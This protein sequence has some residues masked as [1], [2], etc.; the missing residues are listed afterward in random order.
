MKKMKIMTALLCSI[1][2][3]AGCGAKTESKP[4]E[5][6]VETSVETPAETPAETPVETSGK[7]GTEAVYPEAVAEDTDAGTFVMGEAHWDWWEKYRG[8]VDVSAGQQTGMEEYY[9]SVIR[10]LLVTDRNENTVCSP[11]NIYI[12]LSMLAEASDGNTR[13]QILNVLKAGDIEALRS[14]TKALW[15][16]NYLDTPVVKS[17]LADSMWLR[18]D[19][20]YRED[21][22]QRMADLYY[23]SSF[24]GEM[25]SEE[26][27]RQ[28]QEWTDKNTGGLLSEYTK[29]MR[30]DER[31]VLGIISTIYYKA[32]WTDRFRPDRTDKAVFHGAEGDTEVQMM[33]KD[34]MMSLYRT[35][36]FQAVGLSLSDSGMMYFFLPEEGTDVKD[37]AVDAETMSICRRTWDKESSYPIVHLSVPKF[38]V[39]QKTELLDSLERLGITDALDPDLADFAPLTEEAGQIWLN[40]AEH[41]AVVEIDEEGVTG[42]A[43]TDLAMAGAGMPQEE[44]DFVLDKPFFFA[45]VSPDGSI[46]FSGIVQTIN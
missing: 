46:L 2:I 30:L 15:E 33:H 5:A 35:E 22:L 10:E 44:V 13:E 29:D 37:V 24:C 21:T 41:A 45:I 38:K 20:T 14:R 17:L 31:T 26:L 32:A 11:L 4:A 16:A 43:Y 39:S 9:A 23:A 42:A 6:P 25:G 12:A 7:Q 34:D 18:N 8:M 27:N 19:I 36:H 1:A 28:L 3:M 40:A